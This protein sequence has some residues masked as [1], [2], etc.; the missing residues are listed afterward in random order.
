MAGLVAATHSSGNQ[1][2]IV[3]DSLLWPISAIGWLLGQMSS[4]YGRMFG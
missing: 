1:I 4:F 2:E 3:T